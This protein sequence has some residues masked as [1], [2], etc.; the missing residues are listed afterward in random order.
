MLND[1]GKS[2]FKPWC[3]V[4]NVVW[5]LALF[6]MGWLLVRIYDLKNSDV[7]SWVQAFGSIAA[8]L[9][10]FA[11]SNRQAT[12]QRESVAAAELKRKN[13]FKS[14]MLLLAGKHLDDIRRLKRVVQEA[15]YGSDPSEAFEPYIK[16][17]YPLKWPSHLE[18]LKN[19]DI[20]ELDANHISVLMDMQV[21][22]QFALS[23]C[24]RLEDWKA[25]GDDEVEAME[26]L[27]R[28]SDE[29]QDNILYI[30]TEPWDF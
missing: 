21:A 7:A 24:A 23:L 9:G 16:S 18:A 25:Y 4:Q 12:L 15:N 29:T 10:A 2:L 1:Y 20:N 30:Q 8:I 14:I 3:S 11:I 27:E 22:A 5:C 6:Y 13:R 28:F 17:G 19:I 26:R